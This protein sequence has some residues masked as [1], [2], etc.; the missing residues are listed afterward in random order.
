MV[1]TGGGISKHM[2]RTA[3]ELSGKA[4]PKF[5][6]D[7]GP[8]TSS[9]LFDEKREHFAKFFEKFVGK[10]TWLQ[11][12]FDEPVSES[13][14][15][16]TISAADIYMVFGGSTW[17]GY[18]QWERLGIKDLIL[19]RV[20]NGDM[21]ATGGSAGAMIWFDTGYSD[22][23]SYEVPEGQRWNY[24]GVQASGLLPS[25]VTAHYKD[26]DKFGRHRG[27]GFRRFLSYHAGEW[28]TALG[29]ETAAGLVCYDG[30]AWAM[31]VR[32]PERC[33]PPL[34][35]VHVFRAEEGASPQT[36]VPGEIISLSSL[37]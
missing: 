37:K 15:H 16:D 31:D 36:L 8:L 29:M 17:R 18:E 23:R 25:W 2:V 30:L 32:P 34:Q 26:T 11:N 35:T 9:D 19:S 12:S 21:V 4:R 24:I 13:R 3:F 22:S 33:E 5:V 27:T 7:P 14:L 28:K 20:R 10:V 1:I 6:V